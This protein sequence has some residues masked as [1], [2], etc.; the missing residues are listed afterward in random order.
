MLD[1]SAFVQSIFESEG[2]SETMLYWR[3]I[4]FGPETPN[5]QLA[6]YIYVSEPMQDASQRLHGS[7]INEPATWH[8]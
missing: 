2:D 3:I 4:T 5:Y 8:V 6:N 7:F 1:C